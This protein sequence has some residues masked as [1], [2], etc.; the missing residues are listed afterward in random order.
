LFFFDLNGAAPFDAFAQTQSKADWRF[1]TARAENFVAA[2][3]EMPSVSSAARFD[4]SAR[5]RSDGHL[6]AAYGDG[7]AYL[8][9]VNNLFKKQS[10]MLDDMIAVL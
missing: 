6:Y 5:Q 3:P 4:R 2:L 8:I 9:R 10:E 1:Y 7:V